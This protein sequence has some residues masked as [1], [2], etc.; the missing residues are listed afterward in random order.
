MIYLCLQMDFLE[1]FFH[2]LIACL[3]VFGDHSIVHVCF[4]SSRLCTQYTLIICLWGCSDS[5]FIIIKIYI[6]R[7]RWSI[8]EP[9]K[10]EIELG[11]KCEG[12]FSSNI[13]FSDFLPNT[14]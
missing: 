9:K 2:T 4:V 11:F 3:I 5:D 14:P 13:C 1:I 8:A 6:V 10:F 7:R 12:L